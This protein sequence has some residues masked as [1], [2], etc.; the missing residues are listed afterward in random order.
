MAD[1]KL[2]YGDNL[3]VLRRYVRDESVDL[4]YL[5]P[6]FNS[7][8]DYNVLFAE[9]DGTRSSSQIT[10]FEDTWEWNLDAERAYQ[11]VVERGGWVSKAM[12]AFRNFLG[13]SDMMAYLAMMAPRLL[14]LKRVLKVTGSIY[15][16]CDPTA[17]HYLKMLMDAVFRP[18]NF[19]SEITWKRTSS[20][21]AA[22]RW[23]DIHDTI[24]FYSNGPSYVWNDVIVPHSTDYSARYKNL[25]SNGEM[26]ADDNLTGPGVRHGDSGAV[27]RG[28]DV[29]AKGLHW[30]VSSKAV[31]AIVGEEAAKALSTT[32]RLDLL[33]AN[34]YIHWPRQRSGQ[35]PGFPRFKRYLSAGGRIQDVVTDIP[36]INSQAQERLGYP[37]QKPEALLERIIKASSN[38]GDI[39]LDPFC[40]CG[41]A[42]VAA[43]RLQRRWIGIDITP[44]ATTLIKT[45]LADIFGP[46]IRKSYEVIGEPTSVPDA[47]ELAKTEP[48]HFQYWALGLVDARPVEERKGADRGIDGRLYFHVDNSGKT[49]QIIF[50][51]KAGQNINVA[52]VRDLRG[53]IEREKAAIGVLITMEEP[54]RPMLKEAA[55]AGFYKDESAF[56]TGTYPRIQILTVEQLLSGAQVQ[57]PRLLDATF[58]KAPKARGAAVEQL[59]LDPAE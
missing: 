26:W 38:Q 1:N 35:G 42:V 39:V 48:T 45:R 46:E 41:T 22:K 2:F 17:S 51:V 36:P 14:E 24:L 20:H 12:Q 4:I 11:E 50:S 37:T 34:G 47:R 56:D 40:G 9:K 49:M 16:H 57:Y 52:F 18:Q 31:V 28:Y 15:L 13:N 25:D 10:A 21:S 7:R 3:D 44:L 30:K 53:V 8:Q 58:K 54:T 29:T 55:E 59:K 5:D 23:G 19:R 27:W 6:P 32:Q 43:Q 33:D